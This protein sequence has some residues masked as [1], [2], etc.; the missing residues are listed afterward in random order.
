MQPVQH[1]KSVCAKFIVDVIS[2]KKK[3][4]ILTV[5]LYAPTIYL[6][7]FIHSDQECCIVSQHL[8]GSFLIYESDTAYVAHTAK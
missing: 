5:T 2:K 6:L 4:Q 7:G 8:Q 3:N 1:T